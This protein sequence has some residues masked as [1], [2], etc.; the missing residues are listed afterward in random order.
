MFES[1]FSS[2]KLGWKKKWCGMH[3]PPFSGPLLYEAE[4]LRKNYFK[5]LSFVL[6]KFP[7][8][9]RK[10]RVWVMC[11]V[12]VV[13]ACS[14]FSVRY[15]RATNSVITVRFVLFFSTLQCGTHA[16][17][18]TICSQRS[19]LTVLFF[20]SAMSSALTPPSLSLPQLL[21]FVEKK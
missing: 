4:I 1:F 7:S 12:H 3:R 16:R 17:T 6:N 20:S 14:F 8:M 2:S 21:K 15:P 5:I 18:N 9:C 10:R 11:I 19:R 13:F